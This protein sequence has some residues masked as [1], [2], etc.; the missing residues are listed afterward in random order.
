MS[1]RVHRA[2]LARLSETIRTPHLVS[3]AI[4]MTGWSLVLP[5]L[6]YALSVEKLVHLM[7]HPRREPG[8]VRVDETSRILQVAWWASRVQAWR[9]PSN[10]LERSLVAYRFLGRAGAD[11]QLVMGIRRGPLGIEGHV[12]VELDNRPVL[13]SSETVEEFDPVLVFGASGTVLGASDP[14][15]SWCAGPARLLVRR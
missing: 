6:K 5:L 8:E 15:D 4:R 7:A 9:F 10:C 2:R 1:L 13:E 11:P 14:L 3:L 12:W